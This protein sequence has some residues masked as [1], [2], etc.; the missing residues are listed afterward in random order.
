M[1]TIGRA[2]N[3]A[4]PPTRTF[5]M[6]PRSF[7]VSDPTLWNALSVDFKTMQIPQ[8]SFK[9]KLKTYLFT[10]AYDQ[11]SSW[12]MWFSNVNESCTRPSRNGL[13]IRVGYRNDLWIEWIELNWSSEEDASLRWSMPEQPEA[14]WERTHLKPTIK[15]SEATVAPSVA[16]RS[17]MLSSVQSRLIRCEVLTTHHGQP[18]CK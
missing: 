13:S 18:G 17:L 5:R 4:V 15:T 12:I 6:G 3:L 11:W 8:E 14:S 9:S 16:Q 7:A 1:S 10:K 2:W